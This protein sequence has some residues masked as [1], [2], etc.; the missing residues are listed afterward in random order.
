MGVGEAIAL[1]VLNLKGNNTNV[2]MLH[3]G[4]YEIQEN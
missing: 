4:V 1:N 2:S 3:K